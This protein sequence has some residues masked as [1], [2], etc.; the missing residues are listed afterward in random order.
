MWV[1]LVCLG[2]V[3]ELKKTQVF[4]RRYEV[5]FHISVKMAHF[6]NKFVNFF[7]QFNWFKNYSLARPESASSGALQVACNRE[8]LIT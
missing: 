4:L 7:S 1:Y 8:I 5:L 6:L 3:L 2:L